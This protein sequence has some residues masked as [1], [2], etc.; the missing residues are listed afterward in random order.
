MRSFRSR[1]D[2]SGKAEAYRL[3]VIASAF[4][5]HVVNMTITIVCTIVSKLRYPE[6]MPLFDRLPQLDFREVFA[7]GGFVL[8]STTQHARVAY[9]QHFELAC[10]AANWLGMLARLSINRHVVALPWELLRPIP[11]LG[12]AIGTRYEFAKQWKHHVL[13]LAASSAI[14]VYLRRE[15]E[16]PEFTTETFTQACVPEALMFVSLLALV[17]GTQWWLET[18][19]R[20]SFD[21]A[22]FET[23]CP[24]SRSDDGRPAGVVHSGSSATT[25]RRSAR[26]RGEGDGG[27]YA[28]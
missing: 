4:P 28:E 9:I 27:V 3:H 10:D 17:L 22:A 15:S 21:A 26:H 7:I 16:S 20:K 1:D 24:S 13:R 2:T 6:F 23:E 11:A 25:R 8:L 19:D 5:L 18:V 12:S 14:S